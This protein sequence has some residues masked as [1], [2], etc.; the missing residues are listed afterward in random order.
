MESDAETL[1]RVVGERVKQERGQ[2][3][4]ALDQLADAAGVSRR[5]LVNVEHGSVNPSLGT[6]LRVSDALG[7][8]L[9]TFVEPPSPTAAKVVRNGHGAVLWSG[10]NGGRGVLVDGTEP[11]DVVE[12][13]NWTLA[14]EER[15][16]NE[17]HAK[18][19]RELLHVQDGAITVEV[20]A[21]IHTL[22]T[23]D[24]LVF[25][26]DAAHAYANPHPSSARFS[27]TVY[28][29]GVGISHRMEKQ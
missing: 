21:E 15:H 27:L 13:W 22:G 8:G 29:P 24:S 9:P 1:S 4:W 2:R 3:D 7:V 14:P 19:T 17:P 6:L 23:G 12:L 16:V 28:E 25:H 5:M 10:Q 26:G 11:P 18:G 20:D